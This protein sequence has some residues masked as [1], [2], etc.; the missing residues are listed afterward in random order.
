MT[1]L[2]KC[3]A[4]QSALDDVC[5]EMQSTVLGDMAGSTLHSKIGCV[6]GLLVEKHGVE[7]TREAARAVLD[8]EE[9]WQVQTALLAMVKG[10]DGLAAKKEPTVQ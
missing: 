6:L 3:R 2:E 5:D 9:F 8:N 10:G 1:L 4:V 7:D